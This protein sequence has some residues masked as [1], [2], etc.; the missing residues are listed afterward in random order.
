MYF[1]PFFPRPKNK[2]PLLISNIK[3]KSWW[4]ATTTNKT[5]NLATLFSPLHHQ[6]NCKNQTIGITH[7]HTTTTTCLDRFHALFAFLSLLYPF[8]SVNNEKHQ[9]KNTHTTTLVWPLSLDVFYL[10]MCV[11]LRACVYVCRPRA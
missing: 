11:C 2:I 10:H 1:S 4:L 8:P 3:T 5:C 6:Y 9:N 7:P